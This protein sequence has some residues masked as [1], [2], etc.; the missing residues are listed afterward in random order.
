MPVQHW[1][2][3]SSARLG[4]QPVVREL[5]DPQQAAAAIIFDNW[6]P[7]AD[8]PTAK[9]NPV[10][11][12]TVSTVAAV[13]VWLSEQGYRCEF[14]ASGPKQFL[15]LSNMDLAAQPLRALRFL[16]TVQED[17]QDLLELNFLDW[18]VRES[19]T[20]VSNPGNIA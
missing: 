14:V 18:M 20:W 15:D 10:W 6:F 19:Q 5:S 13:S 1:D 12:N 9:E 2:Y 16:A 7:R 3:A 17:S 11:E 4:G 8:E